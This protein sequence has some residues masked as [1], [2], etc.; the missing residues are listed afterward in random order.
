MTSDLTTV[1]GR[2]ARRA[3]LPVLAAVALVL[4]AGACAAPSTGG[5]GT[6]G[7]TTTVKPTTTTTSTTTTTTIPATYKNGRCVGTEGVTIVVDFTPFNNGITVRCALGP[8]TS[9][10]AVLDHAAF[11]HDPG[12]YPGTVCQLNG[13]PTQ[14]HPYCWTTGGYWSYWKSTTAGGP[15]VYSEWGA[16][17]GPRPA[18]GSVE[19]WR[20][21]PFSAGAAVPPR[22]GTSGPVTP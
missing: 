3:R 21:A 6:P 2:R 10:F 7:P 16:G 17:V 19:G 15:W 14:G 13:L 1:M 18:A 8:Q 20:F 5:V 4:L 11:A 12:R 22:I 9:G